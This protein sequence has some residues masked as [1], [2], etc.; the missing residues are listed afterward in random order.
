MQYNFDE[1][2]NRYGTY[3]MKWDGV[4]GLVPGLRGKFIPMMIADMDFKTAQPVIDAM[5]RVADFGMFG[6]TADWAEPAY[7]QAV[8]GWFSRRFGWQF[9][10]QD[11]IYSNGTIEALNCAVQTFSNVGDGVI[12]CRPVYGH[13]TQAIEDECHRKVVDCHLRN[14]G[15]GYYTM[16]YE[17]LEKKCA[18]PRNRIF[19]LCSP[20]NPTGRVW[21]PEELRR[22]AQ[23]CQKHH[24]LLI[25]DEVHCDIVRAGVRHYPLPTVVEDHSNIITLTAV[26]KTFN[27]AGLQC[28]NAI[29]TDPFLRERF[30]NAFGMRCPTPFAIAALIAAYNEGEEWLEQ[31]NAYIDDNLDFA[32]DFL[33]QHL[34][35][36]KAWRPEGTYVLW[37][38][39]SASGLS[40]AEIHA[41][42]YDQALVMLQDGTD[43]DP[44]KGQCWQ[45]MCMPCA[46][47][48]LQE[49][50]ERIADVFQDV[51]K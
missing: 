43:H 49:A 44:E 33:Q 50:L 9:S 20:H 16:D 19:V 47:S 40:D 1:V 31:A 36:V 15:S 51:V 46:R 18:D 10:P 3:S 12:L 6:Y 37:L 23:I 24:V 28:S 21:T 5:H 2:V 13:F 39:L 8:T 45:R 25:S 17:D 32:L 30:K 27:L 35:W 29:I 14:D 42:I 38:D 11:V 41:R 48:V 22:A 26:N 7:A 4:T 34:P